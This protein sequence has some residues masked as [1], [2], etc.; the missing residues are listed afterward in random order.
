MTPL[1]ND[2]LLHYFLLLLYFH[3]QLVHIETE[4]GIEVYAESL[5]K[6]LH[7][8]QGCTEEDFAEENTGGNGSL[9]VVHFGLV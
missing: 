4:I 5:D 9:K 7:W 1:F 3:R 6:T 2:Y 8:N